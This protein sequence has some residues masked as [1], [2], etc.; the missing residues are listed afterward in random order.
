[1]NN[2]F[3][4]IRIYYSRLGEQSFAEHHNLLSDA[5][6]HELQSF[7]QYVPGMQPSGK[8]DP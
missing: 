6:W 3:L 1:M 8:G 5:Q 7:S 2:Q 4:V